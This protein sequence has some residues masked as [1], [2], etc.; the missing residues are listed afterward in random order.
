MEF[1]EDGSLKIE[2]PE[3]RK[4]VR[5][6]LGVADE[7][8]ISDSVFRHQWSE[9]AGKMDEIDFETFLIWYTRQFGEEKRSGQGASLL[10]EYYRSLRPQAVPSSGTVLR[11][12]SKQSA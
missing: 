4:L 10:R 6:L 2:L 5:R 1:D 3:F 12:S 9:A 7:T 11:S 8:Y